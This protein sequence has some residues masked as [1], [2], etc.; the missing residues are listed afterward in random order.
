MYSRIHSV[1]ELYRQLPQ[2]LENS[3]KSVGE[4]KE[5]RNLLVTVKRLENAL[6]GKDFCQVISKPTSF[7][8]GSFSS[9]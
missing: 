8:K 9:E 1:L 7:F 6:E 4:L 3:P 2:S 5:N